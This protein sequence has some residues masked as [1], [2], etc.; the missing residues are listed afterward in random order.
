MS[1]RV[2][3][4]TLAKFGDPTKGSV[5]KLDPFIVSNGRR[6]NHLCIRIQVIVKQAH[7]QVGLVFFQEISLWLVQLAP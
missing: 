5:V 1:K 2:I 6:S 7:L 4:V 3:A